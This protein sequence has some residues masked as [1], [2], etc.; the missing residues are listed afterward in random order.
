[1]TWSI[2]SSVMSGS[3]RTL[4][5]ILIS[6]SASRGIPAS[7]NASA[8]TAPHRADCAAG[9]RMTAEPAASAAN[10]DP[11]GIAT[12]K[13]HGGVTR[14]TWR[15]TGTAPVIVHRSRAVSYTHLRAHETKA[16]LV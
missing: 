7:H 2:R 6:R 8:R 10:V 16:N 4:E 3:P 11:A 14:V 12:G 15:G 5:S 1:M 13:F 9:L